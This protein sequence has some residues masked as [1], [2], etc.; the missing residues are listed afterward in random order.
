[1]KQHVLDHY[2]KTL[3]T[4]LASVATAFADVG[5]KSSAPHQRE[6]LI[7]STASGLQLLAA[8]AS[9]ALVDVSEAGKIGTRFEKFLKDSHHRLRHFKGGASG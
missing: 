9:K 4:Y 2:R 1:M 3:D 5:Q 6:Y 8:S 7:A